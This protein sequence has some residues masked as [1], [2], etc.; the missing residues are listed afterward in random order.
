M[1]PKL[2]LGT[3]HVI[4]PSLI[5]KI[6]YTRVQAHSQTNRGALPQKFMMGHI[7]EIVMTVIIINFF[8]D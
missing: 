2:N 3:R 4:S 5:V 7:G 1:L 6:W 8:V